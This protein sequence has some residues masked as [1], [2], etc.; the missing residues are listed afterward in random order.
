M[1]GGK[2]RKE[3]EDGRELNTIL[4]KGSVIEGKIIIKN[5]VR[6]DGR[7]VG[8]ISSTGTITVGD[9]GEIE[10]DITAI[11][12]IVGGKVKGRINASAK[13]VL[14]ANSVFIGDLQTATL[15]I[16]EG[17]MFEGRCLM[18]GDGSDATENSAQKTSNQHKDESKKLQPNNAAQ[19]NSQSPH[20]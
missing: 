13:A 9:N 10:G 14:E 8:E 4:G 2:N 16:D 20:K 3:S 12:A 18:V 19:K 15:M 1:F 6:V 5:G 11:R 7:V 17:A